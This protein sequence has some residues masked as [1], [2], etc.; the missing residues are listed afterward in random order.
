MDGDGHLAEIEFYPAFRLF[1]DV[2]VFSKLKN[3]RSSLDD[4]IC[5]KGGLDRPWF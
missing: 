5:S 2:R 4:Y 3:L 1:A